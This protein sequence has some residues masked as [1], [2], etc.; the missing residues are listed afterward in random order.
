MDLAIC[1]VQLDLKTPTG[2]A[3]GET[4]TPFSSFEAACCDVYAAMPATAADLLR[5]GIDP[6]DCSYIVRSEDGRDMTEI[7]FSELVRGRAPSPAPDRD[8]N[9]WIR[10]NERLK[11][12][13]EEAIGRFDR[14]SGWMR[15]SIDEAVAIERRGASRARA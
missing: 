12:R 10:L 9:E 4:L 6:M 7:F 14:A 15:R 3:P 13:S 8:A 1:Y 11:R 2:I 5:V